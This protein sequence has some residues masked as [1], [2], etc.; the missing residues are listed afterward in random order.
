FVVDP[1][2]VPRLPRNAEVLELPRV[3][4]PLERAVVDREDRRDAGPRGTA[5]ALGQDD[6][7]RGVP[8]VGVDY[9]GQRAVPRAQRGGQGAAREGGEAEGVVPEGP[10]IVAIDP[11]AIEE[12]HVGEQEGAWALSARR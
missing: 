7:E 12:A 4:H 9:V 6:G 10:A 11:G 5:G 8:I 2:L 1:A 3:D